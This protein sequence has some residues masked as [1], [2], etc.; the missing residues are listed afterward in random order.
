M[1]RM[2][3]AIFIKNQVT[4]HQ[5]VASDD[6]LTHLSGEIKNGQH[7]AFKNYRDPSQEELTAKKD[8]YHK[9]QPIT[10]IDLMLDYRE[11]GRFSEILKFLES[12]LLSPQGS[13]KGSSF[14]WTTHSSPQQRL[15][16]DSGTSQLWFASETWYHTDKSNNLYFRNNG[17]I[18]KIIKQHPHY[19]SLLSALKS[20][21]A[22]RTYQRH[23][24]EPTDERVNLVQRKINRFINKLAED[25]EVKNRIR[26]LIHDIAPLKI[27]KG[28]GYYAKQ[29][30]TSAKESFPFTMVELQV[31][32]PHSYQ[33][34]SWWQWLRGDKKIDLRP[35]IIK[36]PTLES[37]REVGATHLADT[38]NRTENLIYAWWIQTRTKHERYSTHRKLIEEQVEL[39]PVWATLVCVIG[40][41]L[42]CTGLCYG[43]N[44]QAIALL[45]NK[46]TLGIICLYSFIALTVIYTTFTYASS[47]LNTLKKNV[48]SSHCSET[49]S[50]SLEENEKIDHTQAYM[51]QKT[52]LRQ[53]NSNTL[54]ASDDEDTLPN[55]F[56][57]D[58]K[59]KRHDDQTAN[60][61]PSS[62][63]RSADSDSDNSVTSVRSINSNLAK[64][65][66][67]Q[68]QSPKNPY[69]IDSRHPF[70]QDQYP[71]TYPTVANNPSTTFHNTTAY[72]KPPKTTANLQIQPTSSS[73]FKSPTGQ[74][75]GV[76]NHQFGSNQQNNRDQLLKHYQ[77][78]GKGSYYEAYEKSQYQRN[79][80]HK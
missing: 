16:S 50:K 72:S 65:N 10:G 3:R 28:H 62:G 47:R 42:L 56:T 18:T 6:L 7:Q 68:F 77:K 79:T 64:R 15:T 51:S 57:Q 63:K 36:Q 26:N 59:P 8:E 67:E 14:N 70:Q 9:N 12:K 5:W 23:D 75:V 45:T 32:Y 54:M 35:L 71:F 61:P 31:T 69:L 44:M 11:T 1:L 76:D 78:T 46:V 73:T 27:I 4:H 19:K 39:E 41:V 2:L 40:A 22:E 80:R 66:K 74:P 34:R 53:K 24:I 21:C 13:K 20:A 52:G 33:Q 49:Y 37:L 29:S 30:S 48:L 58:T 17:K 55:D 60:L 43:L 25:D 38:C